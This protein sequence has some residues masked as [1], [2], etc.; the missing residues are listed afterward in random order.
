VNGSSGYNDVVAQRGRL[1]VTDMGDK[2]AVG[3]EHI[4]TD[5]DS[6]S[7]YC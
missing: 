4:G 2:D 5:W 3:W 1:E 6:A 7:A